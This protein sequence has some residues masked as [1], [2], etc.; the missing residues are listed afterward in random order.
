MQPVTSQRQ[1]SRARSCRQ[2]LSV[3]SSTVFD[4]IRTRFLLQ[5]YVLL[6]WQQ[7]NGRGRAKRI[8]AAPI[9]SLRWSQESRNGWE[10]GVQRPSKP[11]FSSVWALRDHS[12][13]P[14]LVPAIRF[15][16][17]VTTTDP[18]RPVPVRLSCFTAI[19]QVATQRVITPRPYST[20]PLL[21]QGQ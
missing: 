19:N 14:G 18:N 6:N 4:R 17:S 5:T 11:A 10:R 13:R 8:A 2:K 3:L 15:G 20:T 21:S 9:E 7:S 16:P 12:G 1:L